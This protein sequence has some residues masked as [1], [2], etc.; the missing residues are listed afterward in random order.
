MSR[1]LKLEAI[2]A[3]PM[4]TLDTRVNAI[5]LSAV[6]TIPIAIEAE[7]ITPSARLAATVI[8]RV[9]VDNLV[10]AVFLVADTRLPIMRVSEFR[11]YVAPLEALT[12]SP[13]STN[14]CLI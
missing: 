1:H 9:T 14:E 10:L 12:M 7:R 13:I 6:T 3:A 2:T 8:P 4:I 11:V 5:V